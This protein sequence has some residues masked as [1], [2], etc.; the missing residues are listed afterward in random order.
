MNSLRDYVLA[1]IPR[2][3]AGAVA[4]PADIIEDRKCDSVAFQLS[5]AGE[6]EAQILGHA[7]RKYNPD[8]DG[9]EFISPLSLIWNRNSTPVLVFDSDIQGYHGEMQDSA[10]L[11]GEGESQTFECPKC[12]GKV[13]SIRV[14][15]DYWDACHDLWE[16]E[17]ELNVENYFCNIMF[18]GKCRACGNLTRILDMDV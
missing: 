16:D 13:F 8:Y 6:E 9:D 5:L 17:P 15:F 10:K 7:L 18:A 12:R 2:C 3:I 14:Q 4:A 1:H 11:R